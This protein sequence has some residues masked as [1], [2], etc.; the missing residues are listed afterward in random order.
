MLISIE[1]CAQVLEQYADLEGTRIQLLARQ[2]KIVDGNEDV[3]KA[4]S[5]TES[6]RLRVY[7]H[8][9]RNFSIKSR[10]RKGKV[11]HTKRRK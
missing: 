3:R 5:R 8:N 2:R 9:R 7:V 1:G 10:K 11:N 6:K 4:A